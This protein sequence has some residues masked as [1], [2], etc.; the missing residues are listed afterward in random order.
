MFNIVPAFWQRRGTPPPTGDVTI[1]EGEGTTGYG[2]VDGPALT[3][4]TEFLARLTGYAK[5]T[6]DDVINPFTG[7]YNAGDPVLGVGF[8]KNTVTA[9]FSSTAPTGFEQIDSDTSSGRYNTTPVGEFSEFLDPLFA[10]NLQISD[11]DPITI[12]FS[13]PIAALGFFVTDIGDFAGL[14][15][16]K[17][18][19]DAGAGTITYPL[20]YLVN[21]DGNLYFWG[22]VDTTGTLYTKVEFVSTSGT[23]EDLMG[24][25]DIVYVPASYI[26]P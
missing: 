1:Y 19:K 25:D 13:P 5:L 24:L 17:L 9:T 21:S 7:V 20:T 4:Q 8:V 18:T 23:L 26:I 3:K 6:F 10:N 12:S 15:G 22:I 11:T 2:V 14:V 16:I